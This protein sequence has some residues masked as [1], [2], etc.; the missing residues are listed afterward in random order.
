MIDRYDSSS[1]V[2]EEFQGEVQ[3][4]LREK[5]R[6]VV[7]P[8]PTF[9]NVMKAI[10]QEP[11]LA[12][13]QPIPFMRRARSCGPLVRAQIRLLP[14]YIF[15]VEIV[16]AAGAVAMSNILHGGR[17]GSLGLHVCSNMLMLNM[18]LTMI[19]VFSVKDDRELMLSMPLGPQI[20]VATRMLLAFM[21]N[22]IVGGAALLVVTAINPVMRP[23]PVMAQ[24]IAPMTLLANMVALLCIWHYSG[25]ALLLGVLAPL[26]RTV[27][28]LRPS[29]LLPTWINSAPASTAVWSVVILLA[30]GLL[31]AAIFTAPLAWHARLAG[32]NKNF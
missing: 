13:D 14:R 8:V 30:V 21:S 1:P 15:L 23:L 28:D 26:M 29:F 12:T 31:C 5:E 20:V 9:S 6:N 24:V 27:Q 32:E 16:I 22:I 2:T 17:Y 10:H 18:A 25:V 7:P 3:E 19:L 4:V 11:S